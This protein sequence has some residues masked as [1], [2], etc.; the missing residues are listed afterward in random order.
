MKNFVFILCSIFLSAVLTFSCNDPAVK[1]AKASIN[2]FTIELNSISPG[3]YDPAAGNW[4]QTTENGSEVIF[5]YTL[6]NRIKTIPGKITANIGNIV[7]LSSAAFPNTVPELEADQNLSGEFHSYK[8]PPGSYELYFTYSKRV[9]FG[10]GGRESRDSIIAK[11]LFYYFVPPDLVDNDLDAIDD[12]EE[13]RLLDKYTPFFKFSKEGNSGEAYRPTDV[14]TYIRGSRLITGTDEDDDDVQVNNADLAAVPNKLFF[15][16][17]TTIP[18][19]STNLNSYVEKVPTSY[20][21]DPTDEVRAG[22]SWDECKTKRNIGLYGHVVPYNQSTGQK[23]VHDLYMRTNKTYYKIEYWQF[24]GYSAN[25][26]NRSFADHEGDWTTIQ[27]IYDPHPGVGED[28]IVT[29]FHYAHGN[30]FRFD[31]SAKTGETISGTIK[32]ITGPNARF[33]PDINLAKLTP[34]LDLVKSDDFDQAQNNIV[35][36]KQDPVTLQFTHP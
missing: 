11:E 35:R 36:F 10:P 9:S 31:M 16:L 23:D 25:N 2:L 28:T 22:S 8:L 4:V 12:R 32:E 20:Y 18:P 3:Q 6:K 34:N 1:K 19:V 7:L 29:V 27:L 21:I 33:N 26:P 15:T 30:E 14:L 24:F 5:R 13:K 17:H